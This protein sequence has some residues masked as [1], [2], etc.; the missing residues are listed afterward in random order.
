[1]INSNK[2]WIKNNNKLTCVLA[3]KLEPVLLHSNSPGG[4]RWLVVTAAPFAVG[5]VLLTANGD[6]QSD[7]PLSFVRRAGFVPFLEESGTE[8]LLPS[9]CPVRQ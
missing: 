4:G 1:M 9:V 3:L 8:Q 7:L 6:R 5:D 2:G